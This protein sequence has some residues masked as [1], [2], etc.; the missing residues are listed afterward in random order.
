M[1]KRIGNESVRLYTNPETGMEEMYVSVDLVPEGVKNWTLRVIGEDK[2]YRYCRLVLGTTSIHYL[3]RL[4]SAFFEQS[5]SR[6]IAI[7]VES[8]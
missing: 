3:R 5:D 7:K 6:Y 2:T 1:L 4:L 8:R